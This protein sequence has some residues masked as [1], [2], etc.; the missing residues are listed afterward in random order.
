MTQTLKSEFL[1]LDELNKVVIN[2]L[3]TSFGLDFLLFKDNKGG[4]VDTIHNVRAYYNGDQDIN[5]SDSFKNKFNDREKYD[6]HDYHSHSNYKARGR[7]DKGKQ[8]AGELYDAYRNQI[9]GRGDNRQLDHII[10]SHE[11]SNDPGRV[12]A[13]VDGANLANQSF[14]FQSTEGYI[15][16][17]KDKHSMS[18][19]IDKIVPRTID[20]KRSNIEKDSK[21]LRSM[22]SGTAEER[23]RRRKIED[24][25]ATNQKHLETLQTIDLKSM[26]KSD[27]LARAEYNQQLSKEYCTSREFLAGATV[28]TLKKGFKM[29]AR[30]ALGL[31]LSEVWFELRE[32]FSNFSV[33]SS[34]SFNLKNFFGECGDFIKRVFQRVK[35]RLQDI[36]TAFKNSTVAGVLSSVTEIIMNMFFTTQKL[37]GKLIREMWNSLV[38]AAKLIFFNPDQLSLGALMREVV[39]VLSLGVSV[40]VGVFLNQYLVTV[41]VF[42]FGVELAAFVSALATGII[43]LGMTYFLDHS[44]MMNK[45]WRFLDKLKSQSRLTLEYYQKVNTELDSYLLN[46][47]AIE[48]NLDADELQT[49]ANELQILNCE[50]K[51]AQ[52]LDNEIQRREIKLPFESCNMESTRKWLDSL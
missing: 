20:N 46:L 49:F 15:N 25:I 31:V 39:R 16:N 12:L 28:V 43:T 5:V 4:G 45:V 17:L 14:N 41:F 3:I 7:E 18:E 51:I 42:P 11:V 50:Y 26:R 2:S 34:G 13:G 47:A 21:L 9:M 10:S 32:Y 33:G 35:S 38:S 23:H 37:V 19:F 27:Q 40:A 1:I 30:Q 52:A 48:F 36:L 24:R 6:S 22:P 44:E 29:G 8:S